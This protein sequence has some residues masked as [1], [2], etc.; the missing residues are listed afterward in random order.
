M[1]NRFLNKLFVNVRLE[2]LG[3]LFAFLRLSFSPKQ[4]YKM[5]QKAIQNTYDLLIVP[6]IPY[7]GKKWNFIMKGRVY[8]AKILYERGIVKNI[9]FSGAAVHT[10]FFEG[11]IMALYAQA[12]GIPVENIYTEDKAEHS[13]ENVFLS[14]QK[15]KSLGFAKIAFA[16]DPVQSK[17]L[18]KFIISKVDKDIAIIP[19]IYE[20]LRRINHQMFDPVI[21][22]DEYF[23]ENF[24]PLR[25]RMKFHDRLNGT[26]GKEIK[27]KMLS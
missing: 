23:V 12:I 26:L 8:W 25:K 10:P 18:Q 21:D 2:V 7:N 15:A 6:G 9:M 4:C 5:Y 14:Y 1:S 22:A 27:N 3:F 13:T 16:S 24:V 11:K 19:I 20:E 17:L